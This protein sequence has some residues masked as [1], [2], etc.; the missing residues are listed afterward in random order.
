MRQLAVVDAPSPG[1]RPVRASPQNGPLAT[2]TGQLTFV[3]GGC[4]LALL[5]TV[6]RWDY[7]GIV[8][9]CGYCG[10]HNEGPDERGGRRGTWPPGT[11]VDP[12]DE[13]ALVLAG[14]R[15]ALR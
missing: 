10:A 2:G 12:R 5:V 3:C 8:I 4:R 15:S 11:N 6:H 13:A 1:A 9:R 7:Q 14:P